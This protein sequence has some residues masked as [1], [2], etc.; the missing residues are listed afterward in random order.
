MKA[1]LEF[2]SGKKTYVVAVLVAALGVC[3][4]ME[5][6]AVPDALYALLGAIG[7]GTLRA[8]VNKAAKA[9]KDLKDAMSD[10]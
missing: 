2:L 5:W 6:F 7:L 10:A 1:I 8:G 4:G 9:T 3:Q